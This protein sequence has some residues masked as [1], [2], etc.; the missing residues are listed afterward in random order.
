MTVEHDGIEMWN[1]ILYALC[2]STAIVGVRILLFWS[3]TSILIGLCL[4]CIPITLIY[5]HHIKGRKEDY[6]SQI[7]IRNSC[8]GL[9][10][11]LI[12]VFYNLY[13]ADPF[14][15]LDYGILSVGFIIILLNTNLFR[16]LKLDE[17]M[18]SFTTYFLFVFMLMHAFLFSGVELIL[19]SPENPILT[20][21]TKASSDISAYFLN[22]IKPTT[23]YEDGIGRSFVSIDFNGFNVGIAIACSGVESISVFL[24]AA[25]G[26]FIATKESNVKKAGLCTIMGV[27]IL[28]FMNVL[29]IMTIVMAGYYFGMGAAMLVHEHLGWILFILGMAVFWY[30]VM[31][32]K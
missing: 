29:R 21:M 3:H 5:I 28:F 9:L 7:N 27:S 22:F 15:T 18:I 30:I 13:T 12:D 14:G 6:A 25:I 8:L 17:E 32:R 10:L 31:L 4:I 20:S 11:I 1:R 24:S 19:N 16:F 23:V 2:I 26:Y